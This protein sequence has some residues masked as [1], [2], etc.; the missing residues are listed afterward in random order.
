MRPKGRLEESIETVIKLKRMLRL[1]KIGRNAVMVESIS[2]E[3]KI[4]KKYMNKLWS[5]EGIHG[6]QSKQRTNNKRSK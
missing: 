3:L 5:K 1:A 4:A 2:N 6:K